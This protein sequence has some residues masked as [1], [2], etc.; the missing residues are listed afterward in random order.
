VPNVT[1]II[2]GVLPAD[3]WRSRPGAFSPRSHFPG[4]GVPGVGNGTG[5]LAAVVRPVP[6]VRNQAAL[7]V[8]TAQLGQTDNYNHMTS[9]IAVGEGASGPTHRPP[10]REPA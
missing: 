8:R 6:R 2:S 1:N 10:H 5:L 9:V 7:T 3:Q 4:T